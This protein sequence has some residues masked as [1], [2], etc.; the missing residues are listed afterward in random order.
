MELY[1]D[2]PFA[3]GRIS[4]DDVAQKSRLGA[5]IEESQ[6]VLDGIVAYLIADAI[7]QVIHQPAF[8]DGQ[9]LVEGPCDV[10]TDGRHTFQAHALFFGEALNLLFC[11]IP[12]VGTAKVEFV[13]VFLCLY[14]AKNG[15]E[16]RQFH[17][18]DAMQLVID[19]L[20][21][22]LELFL[23]G[24]VLPLAAT[25]NTEMVTEGRRAYLTKFYKTHHLA[26]GKG[27]LLTTN[28]NVT[29][30]TRYAERHKYH[31]I[32]PVEKALS[33]GGNRLYCYALKER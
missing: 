27:M 12:L 20:L 32:I 18:S 22:E 2:H 1:D 10:E 14:A 25:A 29:D 7:V 26:L 28:L 6:T 16:L 31:Q 8:L 21:F 5:K 4:D 13:A 33:L 11:Q 9:D 19:L 24:Q 17:F 30:V 15:A 3:C 23:I